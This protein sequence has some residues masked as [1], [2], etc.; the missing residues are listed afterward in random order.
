MVVMPP[1]DGLELPQ[2]WIAGSDDN[3]HYMRIHNVG[4]FL[5]LT[6][7]FGGSASCI[8]DES[9]MDELG[10]SCSA[11]G[12]GDGADNGYDCNADS[13]TANGWGYFQPLD[14]V[15]V[16]CPRSCGLC[17]GDFSM[18]AQ[19]KLFNLDGSAGT[20]MIN[21]GVS[22]TPLIPVRLQC[23]PSGAPRLRPFVV[24]F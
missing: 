14:G 6:H 22:P 2:D 13:G 21:V 9:F 10:Y 1:C 4:S 8:D 3:G 5:T 23:S 19:L 16:A 17:P 18:E 12:W 24:A 20:F 11:W 7:D 15:R